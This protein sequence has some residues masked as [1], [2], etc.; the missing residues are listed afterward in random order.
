MSGA[1]A[2]HSPNRSVQAR[3]RAGIF[4]LDRSGVA[5]PSDGDAAYSGLLSLETDRLIISYYSQHAYLRGPTRTWLLSGGPEMGTF[6]STGSAVWC[7]SVLSE[8]CVSGVDTS[9]E[10][11]ITA[12]LSGAVYR[13][14]YSASLAGPITASPDL[15][16]C[17]TRCEQRDRVRP[18]LNH[19]ATE[20][21]VRYV[22]ASYPNDLRWRPMLAE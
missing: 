5:L 19:D 10:F 9:V 17:F 12:T 1:S 3:R 2:R 11:Y 14:R 15:D 4:L 22:A 7:Q 16:K 18:S 8:E 6:S 20:F 21:S 13:D